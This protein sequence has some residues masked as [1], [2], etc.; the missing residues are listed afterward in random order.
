MPLLYVPP[1]SSL[2]LAFVAPAALLA[3][4]GVAAIPSHRA[5]RIAVGDALRVE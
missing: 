5:S 2:A 4:L 3:A 1:L